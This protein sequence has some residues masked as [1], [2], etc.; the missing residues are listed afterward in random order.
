MKVLLC[1]LDGFGINKNKSEYDATLVAKNFWNLLNTN[2]HKYLEASGLSV[3]LP[4]GQV[5]NSEVGHTTIGLGRTLKQDLVQIDSAIQN[6]TLHEISE[7]KKFIKN[8]KESG[9]ACHLTGL[10]SDGGVHSHINHFIEVINILSKNNI[11]VLIH[12]ILDG[13]DTP[14]KSA[15]LYL[16]KLSKTLPQNAK[17]VSLCG[18]FFAM[19]RDNRF[20]RTKKAYDLITKQEAVVFENDY[21]TAIENSY[22]KGITDEF[23][24]PTAIGE[25]Y[26]QS[27][28]DCLMI[29]NFRSDRAK[30]IVRSLGE[31]NYYNSNLSKLCNNIPYKKRFS[32]ILCMKEYD[33]KFDS[34]CKSIFKPY[35]ILNSLSDVLS[36]NQKKQVRI[37]ETEKYAHVTFFFNGGKEECI[38]GEKRI[39]IDSPKVEKY[40]QTPSMSAKE[41]TK[42]VLSELKNYENDLIVVNYANPDMI[43]H[44]GNF[45]ATK[46]AIKITDECLGEIVEEAKKQNFIVIITSDHGN[47]EEMVTENGVVNTSHTTNF[48]PFVLINSPI[49]LQ[50]DQ[51]TSNTNSLCDKKAYGCL[52]DIA[53]TIL[54]LLGL[55]VPHEMTGKSMVSNSAYF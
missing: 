40:D 3:G 33:K 38:A 42:N 39:L 36:K 50:D 46:E 45:E 19:D 18:R 5:G 9:G 28:D 1:I 44:T 6:Q 4:D 25:K 2:P 16:D 24:E 54:T 14:Q 15:Q 7:F 52:E 12:T 26:H 35:D 32:E 27:P 51:A 47:A 21:A 29:I 31:E 23:I 55:Q 8:L 20:E 17:I 10:L 22:K 53:P 13:R 37:A 48:V 30:Q 11:N 49:T 34:F 41:I 43:G